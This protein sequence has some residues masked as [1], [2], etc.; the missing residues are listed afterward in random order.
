MEN[1][2]RAVITGASSGIGEAFANLLASQGVNLIIAARRGEHLNLLASKLTEKFKVSVE[3][4]SL[5]LTEELAAEKLFQFA[6]QDGKIVNI[7][8]NNAG[9]GPYRQFVKTSL[10]DHKKT[11]QLNINSLTGLTHLFATHML[12]HGKQSH[13][14]NVA[15]V[16]SYQPIPKFAA[17]CASKSYVRIFSEILH[18]ELKDSNVSVSCLCPGGTKTEFLDNNNQKSKSGDAFLMDAEKVAFIGLKG[19]F[20][21]KSVIIPGLF[22]KLSCLFPIFLPNSMNLKIAEKALKMAVEEKSALPNL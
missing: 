10:D 7:L 12:G 1:L 9:V 13:I 6:T 19:T 3:V 18:Y 8:I 21:K 16:A 11:L 4:L 17:Y 15:S 5:D 14:L 20:A 2:K 22:N